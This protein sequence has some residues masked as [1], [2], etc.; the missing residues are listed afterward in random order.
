MTLEEMEFKRDKAMREMWYWEGEIFR[1]KLKDKS[2]SQEVTSRL[3]ALIGSNL[4]G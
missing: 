2:L 3:C 4:D 1:Y